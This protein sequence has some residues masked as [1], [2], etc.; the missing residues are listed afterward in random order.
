[1]TRRKCHTQRANLPLTPIVISSTLGSTSQ[2]FT[3]GGGGRC[4]RCFGRCDTEGERGLGLSISDSDRWSGVTPYPPLQLLPAGT[5]L[6]CPR[7]QL[8]F[9]PDHPHSVRRDDRVRAGCRI[10]V[11]NVA[12]GPALVEVRQPVPRNASSGAPLESHRRQGCRCPAMHSLSL[13]R[14][15]VPQLH[16]HV[17]SA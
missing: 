6:A 4:G 10:V 7:L 16:P 1:M 11:R 9:R 8:S 5:V 12:G 3:G 17:T 13:T 14:R 2:Y 15:D